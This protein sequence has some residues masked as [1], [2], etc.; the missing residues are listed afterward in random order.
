MLE[1]WK[2]VDCWKLTQNQC[3]RG[4][5]NPEPSSLEQSLSLNFYWGSMK[6]I[7]IQMLVWFFLTHFPLAVFLPLRPKEISHGKRMFVYFSQMGSPIFVSG[8]FHT[9][10][11]RGKINGI[12]PAAIRPAICFRIR[13]RDG[14]RITGSAWSP[15]TPEPPDFYRAALL[16]VTAL[17]RETVKYYLADFV[18]KAGG[19]GTPQIH[20]PFLLKNFP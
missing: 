6:P 10:L 2:Q 19:G 5:A 20:N 1:Q 4:H 7:I 14:G 17:L 9:S 3:W 18:R 13:G 16:G 8:A 11:I 15:P 12:A